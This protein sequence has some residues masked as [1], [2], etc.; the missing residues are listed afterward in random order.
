M[1]IP[2][3]AQVQ[4]DLSTIFTSLSQT[5]HF[6]AEFEP[7]LQLEYRG[8]V[9]RMEASLNACRQKAAL[10]FANRQGP[11]GLQLE[12]IQVN[13]ANAGDVLEEL[14]HNLKLASSLIERKETPDSEFL[15]GL[16]RQLAADSK[17]NQG[18]RSAIQSLLGRASTV[19]QPNAPVPAPLPLQ[20]SNA[21]TIQ[22]QDQ[23]FKL[24]EFKDK[25]KDLCTKNL[26][27]DPEKDFQTILEFYVKLKRNLSS[28]QFVCRDIQAEAEAFMSTVQGALQVPIQKQQKMES[29]G[30]A[31]F[32]LLKDAISA[33]Q[34]DALNTDPNPNKASQNV[35]AAFAKLSEDEKKQL[36]TSLEEVLHKKG[37]LAADKHLRPELLNRKF[38][39]WHLS[40]TERL[41]A[42]EALLQNKPVAAQSISER[43]LEQVKQATAPIPQT[44]VKQATTPT[45][46]APQMAQAV[47]PPPGRCNSENVIATIDAIQ[48]LQPILSLLGENSSMLDMQEAL[49]RLF[50]ESSKGTFVFNGQTRSVE[51][52]SHFH[53]YWIHKNEKPDQMV[54]DPEYGK[55]AMNGV[56]FATNVERRRAI[57]RTIMEL[58]LAAGILAYETGIAGND[59]DLNAVLQNLPKD[60]RDMLPHEDIIQILGNPSYSA[61][62][63][64]KILRETIRLHWKEE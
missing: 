53:I 45:P 32:K 6:T 11:D 52:Q 36:L 26:T 31:Q 25:W 5:K 54:Q 13:I 46:Q 34:A 57:S 22:K 63:N 4:S 62:M 30:N 14:N 37:V 27:A 47:Q 50:I 28:I 3:I 39:I 40:Y 59:I 16:R 18:N 55:N 33:A 49:Q 23:A 43:M 21:Q 9:F 48:E 10:L 19:L 24:T 12:A 15:Q 29:S 17:I 64:L 7:D 38:L 20:Q 2:T 44:P 42:V 51:E 61:A 35:E 41:A 60:R 8:E 58:V 1:A 56:I